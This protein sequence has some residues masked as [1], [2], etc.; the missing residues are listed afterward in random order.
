MPQ[1][2]PQHDGDGRGEL[3]QQGDP[4]L[5]VLDRGEVGE[6]GARDGEHAEGRDEREVAAQQVPPAAQHEEG[7]H[8]Q[9]GGG[10]EDA[11]DHGRGG[12]PARVEQSA[13]ER[14][15]QPERRRRDG[16]QGEPGPEPRRGDPADVIGNSAHGS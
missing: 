4:D 14:A 11:D 7:G 15:G 8:K 10:H 16:G 5:Q 6:L 1:P 2:H 12:T 9:H 13:G 3:D